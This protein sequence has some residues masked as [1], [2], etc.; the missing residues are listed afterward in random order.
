MHGPLA[1]FRDDNGFVRGVCEALKPGLVQIEDKGSWNAI[2]GLLER[3]KI[4]HN[5]VNPDLDPFLLHRRSHSGLEIGP[6]IDPVPESVGKDVNSE[7]VVDEVE[8][9]VAG[10]GLGV[11]ETIGDVVDHRLALIVVQDGRAAGAFGG[12]GKTGPLKG[13]AV[14]VDIKKRGNIA[15]GQLGAS[16]EDVKALVP[17]GRSRCK[18]LV[19]EAFPEDL[20][21]FWLDLLFPCG[22]R[23]TRR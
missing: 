16:G 13:D 2:D 7:V 4:A 17:E 8:H 1:S 14:V 11:S 6:A 22:R 15:V 21:V 9:V 19:G 10:R 3:L 18:L 23:R 12:R 20:V 5:R